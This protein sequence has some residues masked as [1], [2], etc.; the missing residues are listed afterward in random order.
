MSLEE[1]LKRAAENLI[2]SSPQHM[3]QELKRLNDH[4]D[5]LAPDIH[6]MVNILEDANI[7]N[8]TATLQQFHFRLWGPFQ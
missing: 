6:K 2:S 8:L 7:R 1:D 4:L 3:I 5:D